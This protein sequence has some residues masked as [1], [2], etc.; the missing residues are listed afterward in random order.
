M[1][2]KEF[3]AQNPKAAI[4]FSGGVDSAY[5]LY[6]AVKNGAD[7]KAYYV[8]SPFQPRFELEDAKCLVAELGAEME[9]IPLNVLENEDVS[10]NPAERCYHCKRAILTAIMDKAGKDSYTLLLDGSNASDDAADRPGM[11]ALKEL[12]VRSPL[13]ECGLTKAEIRHLSKEAGLFTHDKPAYACLATRIPT[14]ETI[15]KEKLEATEK[16]EEYLR[17][18]GFENFRVR[19][20]NGCARIQLRAEDM[21]KAVAQAAEINRELKKYY[22]SV[23]LDMEARDEQ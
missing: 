18:L 4:A 23:M 2:L 20:F 17:S 12:S 7:V 22:A 6:A 14:G 5:L 16:A 21:P 11:R 3:F 13:R 15:T 19:L 10:S 9:I 8:K 1:E